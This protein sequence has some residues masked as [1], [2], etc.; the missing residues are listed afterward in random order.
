[1]ASKNG[2]ELFGGAAGGVVRKEKSAEKVKPKEVEVVDDW[3][4]E[5]DD[6]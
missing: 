4:M 2:F 3:E 6:V 1:L 5:A